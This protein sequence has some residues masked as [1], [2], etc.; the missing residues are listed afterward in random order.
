MGSVLRSNQSL[1]SIKND[2]GM[3]GAGGTM[4]QI[5]WYISFLSS[6]CGSL[7]DSVYGWVVSIRALDTRHWGKETKNAVHICWEI[8]STAVAGWGT[9]GLQGGENIWVQNSNHSDFPPSECNNQ[10][11]M[12]EVSKNKIPN[13]EGGSFTVCKNSPLVNVSCFLMRIQLLSCRRW[14]P[15][16]NFYQLVRSWF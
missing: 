9:V 3:F 4:M 14:Y 5:K 2:C 8:G 1:F 10:S 6:E 15:T 7:E 13:C 16:D 12:A 11:K